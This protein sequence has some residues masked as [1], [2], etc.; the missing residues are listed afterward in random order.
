MDSQVGDAVV[1][2]L[3]KKSFDCIALDLCYN[4]RYFLAYVIVFAFFLLLLPL[5]LLP[6][7]VIVVGQCSITQSTV[8]QQNSYDFNIPCYLL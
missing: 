6:T 5:L 1:R 3:N 8:E 7:A 2:A 4:S